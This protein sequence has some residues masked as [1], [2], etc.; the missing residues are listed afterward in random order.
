MPGQ[1]AIL[2]WGSLPWDVRPEFDEQHGSWEFDGPE[3]KVEFSRISQSRHGALTLVIDPRNGAVCRVTYAISKRTDPEDA[4]RDLRC[5]EHTTHSNIGFFFA[6]GSSQRSRDPDALQSI[7]A[8]A[9]AKKFDMVVWT[10]LNS[11]FESEYGKPFGIDTALA[12]L[13]S[14]D[15]A[16]RSGALE[17]V[18]RT[19]S[20]IDTPLRR[21]LEDHPWLSQ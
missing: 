16:A 8:W 4:I 12:Y 18:R 9:R 14:L 11:N 10:D 13:R 21:A 3:L 5:R 6:N 20:F 17:Y 19:K 1:I 7:A 2:G 15:D